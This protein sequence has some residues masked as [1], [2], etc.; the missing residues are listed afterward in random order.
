MNTLENNKLIAEFF[1]GKYKNQTN[2]P[3]NDNEIWLP[4]FGVCDLGNNGKVLKFH[5]DWNWLMEVVEKIE[6]SN[7]VDE[8]VIKKCSV[9]GF[10]VLITPISYDTFNFFY[11]T[12]KDETKIQ[13]VYNACLLFIEWYNEQNN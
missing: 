13:T 3:L 7:Y 6:N 9:F 10:N 1:G 8:F 11:C 12:L 4:K 2:I 5:N